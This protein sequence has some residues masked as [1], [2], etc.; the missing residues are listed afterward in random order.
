[1]LDNLSLAGL[2]PVGRNE[3]IAVSSLEDRQVRTVIDAIVSAIRARDV[4][5]LMKHYA[6]NAVAFDLQA[7]MQHR[8]AVAIRKRATE[9]F[10]AYEGPLGYEMRDLTIVA[11]EE[12]AFCHS[13]TGIKGKFK[14]GAKVEMWWRATNGFRRLNGEWVI[15]HAHNSEPFDVATGK[16][17]LGLKE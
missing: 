16:A 13:L 14:D 9:W 10:A 11:D 3:E 1:M 4:D 5:A 7:P 8:G 2:R 12:V 17:L 15:T 6:P